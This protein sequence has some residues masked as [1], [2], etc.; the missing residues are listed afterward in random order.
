MKNESFA[1]TLRKALEDEISYVILEE[2]LEI[3]ESVFNSFEMY[4]D[5]LN[6]IPL[7][8]REPIIYNNIFPWLIRY[9]SNPLTETFN[10]RLP[11]QK[12]AP[13]EIKKNIGIIEKFEKMLLENFSPLQETIELNNALNVPNENQ[14]IKTIEAI[15][16][17]LKTT[18]SLKDDLKNKDFKIFPKYKYYPYDLETKK[19]LQT[20]LLNLIDTYDIKAAKDYVKYILTNIH[21]I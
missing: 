2:S 8:D 9:S 11:L 16:T 18:G 14:K 13:K 12:E 21:N 19:E 3:R 4:G 20:I 7:E 5:F 17:L 15:K 1:K 6:C 10:R